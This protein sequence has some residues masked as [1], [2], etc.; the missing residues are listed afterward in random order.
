MPYVDPATVQATDPGDPLT[1]AWCDV[2][3]DNFQFLTD[4]P[5]CSVRASAPQSIAHNTLTTL[6]ADVETY[7]T[8]SMHS[9][10]SNTSRLTAQTAGRF[11]AEATVNW[12]VQTAGSNVPVLLNFLVDGTTGF[13]VGQ[14]A[15]LNSAS[16]TTA[17]SGIRSLV[18]DA[19]QFAEVRVRQET[20]FPL[21]CTLEEFRLKWD[22]R[23]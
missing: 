21:G 20:S 12:A 18:L 7:D 1:A 2:V 16:R 5:Q 9:L 8:D 3:R 10:V 15:A 13:N 4:P 17:M 14:I 22:S 23:R 6:T 19:G 11:S